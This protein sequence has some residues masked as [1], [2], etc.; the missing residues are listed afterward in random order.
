MGVVCRVLARIGTPTDRDT[1]LCCLGRMVFG[2]TFLYDLAV[3]SGEGT[4][5]RR[6]SHLT[7]LVPMGS[8]HTQSHKMKPKYYSTVTRSC[9]SCRRD[10][11]RCQ[12][13]GPNVAAIVPNCQD[14]E[15]APIKSRH[16]PRGRH[17]ESLFAVFNCDAC[18]AP[19]LPSRVVSRF[20]CPRMRRQLHQPKV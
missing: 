17:S 2:A 4:I 13:V 9:K 8:S 19:Q 10:P 14:V 5:L 3:N 12:G 15:R 18:M 11:L 7:K 20:E 16:P 6:A 1:L